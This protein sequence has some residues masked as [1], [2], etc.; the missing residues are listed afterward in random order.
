MA[1]CDLLVIGAGPG[2]GSAALHAARAG[3][4]T[5]IVE[6]D[7]D[8]GV[9]VHC[10]E[11]LSQIAVDNLDLE[12]PDEVIALDCKGIRVIFPD[13]T[14]RLL[15]EKGYVLEKHTFEQWLCNEAVKLGAQLK[16]SHKVKSMERIYNS[17]N[18][19]FS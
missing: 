4:S 7:S 1:D 3:L 14:S 8:V 6:A 12:L 10:G 19:T 5:V 2:G 16:L 9:P 15:T 18:Q 13:G 17:E 11:C